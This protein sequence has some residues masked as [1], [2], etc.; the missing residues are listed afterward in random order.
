MAIIDNLKMSEEALEQAIQTF[1]TKKLALENSYLKIS[2]E[3]RTLD[4]T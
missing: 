1:E 4:G 2:N 3:V